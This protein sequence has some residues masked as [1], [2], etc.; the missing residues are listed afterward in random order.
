VAILARLFKNLQVDE[1]TGCWLWM[2]CLQA[3]GYG[4]IRLFP[5][6]LRVHRVAYEILVGPIAEGKM[7][8]HTCHDPLIC[9]GGNQCVH[10]RCFNPDHLEQVDNVT[11]YRR[12]CGNKASLA[13]RRCITHCPKGHEYSFENTYLN[14]GSRNCRECQRLR[15]AEIRK[16][17]KEAIAS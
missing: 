10:R 3:N 7:L 12:G 9:Q 11:N 17:R 15:M 16:T 6:T 13:D 14:Q 4:A 2:G 8:D 1:R 5:K